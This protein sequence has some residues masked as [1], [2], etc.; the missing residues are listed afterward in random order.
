MK[1]KVACFVEEL[2][3]INGDLLLQFVCT[4]KIIFGKDLLPDEC[5]ARICLTFTQAHKKSKRSQQ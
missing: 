1:S 5:I 3:I 4:I 2:L